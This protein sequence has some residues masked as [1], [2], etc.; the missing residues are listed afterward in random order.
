MY[1]RQPP[2]AALSSNAT[3]LP[4]SGLTLT[5]APALFTGRTSVAGIGEHRFR[6]PA[7]AVPSF[8]PS[9]RVPSNNVNERTISESLF[10]YRSVEQPCRDDGRASHS[11][12]VYGVSCATAAGNTGDKLLSSSPDGDS[13]D[14]SL[15]ETAAAAAAVSKRRRRRPSNTITVSRNGL[16]M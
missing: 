11:S 4:G 14:P 15:S 2:G 8:L 12:S 5:T 10:H 1:K 7:D 3:V 16:V 6:M 13:V 9:Q